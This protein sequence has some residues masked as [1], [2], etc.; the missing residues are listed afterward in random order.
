MALRYPFYKCLRCDVDI[1]ELRLPITPKTQVPVCPK[2]LRWDQ[3]DVVLGDEATALDSEMV[4]F[5][6]GRES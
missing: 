6:D 3:I 4:I 1:A 5:D 2:C